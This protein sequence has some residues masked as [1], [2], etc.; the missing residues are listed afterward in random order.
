[1]RWLNGFVLL[2]LVLLSGC[3]EEKLAQGA[4]APALAAFDLHGKDASL[5]SWKGKGVYLNF[6]S[7]SCGGCLAEMDT[8]QALSKQYGDNVVVVAVNTDPDSVDIRALLAKHQ[9]TYPVLRDQLNITQ[10]RYQVIGTPTSVMIDRQGRV[11]DLHQGG[12]KPAELQD[13]FIRLASN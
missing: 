6:W 2:L 3:K 12:R 7:A 11:L 5:D 13:T 4:P 8:L 1:M 9:I 10:E